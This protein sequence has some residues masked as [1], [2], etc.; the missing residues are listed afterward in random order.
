MDHYLLDEELH[1]LLLIFK[2]KRLDE[3]GEALRAPP[4][5]LQF[6]HASLSAVDTHVQLVRLIL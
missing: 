4:D 2:R 1:E 6:Q 5:D 3:T